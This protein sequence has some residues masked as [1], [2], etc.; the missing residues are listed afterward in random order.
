MHILCVLWNDFLL[1]YFVII[2]VSLPRWW[3]T[4]T[5]ALTLS[6]HISGRGLDSFTC[7]CQH[8]SV[9]AWWDSWHLT[10]ARPSADCSL[11]SITKSDQTS[12]VLPVLSSF[13]TGSPR[14]FG[15]TGP[16]LVWQKQQLLALHL[17]KNSELETAECLMFEFH[18][19]Q[20]VRMLRCHHAA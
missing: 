17:L 7:L 1:F 6:L 14:M 20:C 3:E 18:H 11:R 16:A 15:S 12:E 9:V 13:I 4:F 8:Q 19:S 5:G 10:G 2:R